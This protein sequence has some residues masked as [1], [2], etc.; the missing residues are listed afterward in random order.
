MKAISRRHIKYKRSDAANRKEDDSFILNRPFCYFHE[1]QRLDA[2]NMKARY[3]AYLAMPSLPTY[4]LCHR[5]E[6]ARQSATPFRHRLFEAMH[7]TASSSAIRRRHMEELHG[8]G[9]D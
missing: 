3:T 7:I 1:R 6:H 2:L 9:A 8:H 5:R 4:H